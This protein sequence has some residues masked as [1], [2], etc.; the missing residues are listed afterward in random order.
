MT[1]M[2]RWTSSTDPADPAGT[3][4][5]TVGGTTSGLAGAGADER[6]ALILRLTTA[7]PSAVTS[8]R[9]ADRIRLPQ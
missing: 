7:A 8:R 5:Y 9:S 2:T 4:T 6:I 3:A 1:S